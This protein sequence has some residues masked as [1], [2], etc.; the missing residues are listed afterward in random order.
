MEALC[1]NG[2]TIVRIFFSWGAVGA[3]VF[4]GFGHLSESCVLLRRLP[5]HVRACLHEGGG[6]Q[7]GEVTCSG[8]PH[9]SCKRDQIKMRDYMDRWVTTP[10]WVTSP[11]WGPPPPCKQALRG[12]QATNIKQDKVSKENVVQLNSAATTKIENSKKQIKVYF[13][14]TKQQRAK[15]KERLSSPVP[16]FPLLAQVHVCMRLYTLSL[17]CTYLP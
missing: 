16:F 9:L 12:T 10:K 11:T 5:L 17:K 7:T 6:P 4:C 14:K 2:K 1:L 8:S 3:G 13:G 15:K